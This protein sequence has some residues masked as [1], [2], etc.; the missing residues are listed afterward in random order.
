MNPPCAGASLAGGRLRGHVGLARTP[1]RTLA[2]HDRAAHQQLAAPDTPGLPALK[3]A[4]QAGDPG[5]ASPAHGLRLFHV[6]RR[7]CEEQLRVPNAGKIE[8]HRQ[9][10]LRPGHHQLIRHAGLADGRPGHLPNLAG[11]ADLADLNLP[12]ARLPPR[13]VR[14]GHP[15][16]AVPL[17]PTVASRHC[18]GTISSRL[19]PGTHQR[20]LACPGTWAVHSQGRRAFVRARGLRGH[21]CCFDESKPSHPIRTR[22]PYGGRWS[23]VEIQDG[24]I[25]PYQAPHQW[26]R[27]R[28]RG[29]S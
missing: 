19:P 20:S 23:A 14:A 27:S 11:L 8:S 29:L 10:G 25:W 4:C 3:R 1:A 17:P 9:C 24:S 13:R 2:R 18:I 12:D 28:R 15:G 5:P 6:L 16:P 22:A 26:S 21:R 7:L